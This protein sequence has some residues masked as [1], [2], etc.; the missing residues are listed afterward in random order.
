MV[1]HV[2]A[3]AMQFVLQG[4]VLPD[5]ARADICAKHV[6]GRDDLPSFYAARRCNRT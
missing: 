6:C 1:K 5:H 4:A 3:R 2:T